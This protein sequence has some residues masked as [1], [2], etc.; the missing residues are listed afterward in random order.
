MN[1]FYSKRKFETF[2]PYCNH[3]TRNELIL[4]KKHF[5]SKTNPIGFIR[6]CFLDNY[7][8]LFSMIF[9][10][11]SK[12][13]RLN[14]KQMNDSQ[15]NKIFIEISRGCTGNC[16][17][18]IIKKA[19]GKIHS[20]KIENI[21]ADIEKRYSSSKNLYLVADDCGCYGVDIGSNLVELIYEIN[22]R[23]P[24]LSITINYLNP[25][26][27]QRYS[28]EYIKLFKEVNIDV[29]LTPLQSGSNRIVKNMN[30][31]YDI[32]KVIKIVGQIRNISPKTLIFSHFIIGYPGES[33]M[34]F[35]KTLSVS[36]HFDYPMS[37]IYSDVK[38]TISSS[39][40]HKK[41]KF[42]AISRFFAS[43]L[44]FNFVI[45]FRLLASSALETISL[46]EK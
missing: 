30:R 24:D 42:V 35:L 8:F 46:E 22:E 26:H 19:K 44:F 6:N 7:L 39:L 32:D 9:Y 40:S 37:F 20:R 1:F 18:C 43:V 10:P 45:F 34:D 16:S 33:T 29:V 27:L 28:D 41:S 31:D 4:G 14:Y 3:E 36:K 25:N 21:I 15:T 11:F 12:R 17:Y 23:F 13:I 38:G 5:L 2:K